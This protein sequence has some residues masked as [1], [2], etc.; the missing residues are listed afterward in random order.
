VRTL[1]TFVAV[2]AAALI[3]GC[4]VF[5]KEAH[6][7]GGYLDYVTDEFWLKADSK[8][9]RALR[10]F[11]IEASLSRIA[12]VSPKNDQDRQLMAIK[13]GATTARARPVVGCAF[14]NDN[15][16]KVAAAKTDPCFYFDSAM[17]DYSTALFDL[18]LIAFPVEDVKNLLNTVS[19]T[20]INPVSAAELLTP[21]L[22]VAKD[23]LKYGRIVG[24]LY[25]DTVELEVQVWLSTPAQDQSDIPEAY[26]ITE[27]TVANL[28]AAYNRKNDDMVAWVAEIAALR[29]QG[30]EPIP[31][32]KFILE[33]YALI[34]Y[35]CGLITQAQQ[36]DSLTTCY[37]TTPIAVSSP[38]QA[39][40]LAST[41]ERFMIPK[42]VYTWRNLPPLVTAPPPKKMAKDN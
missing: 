40:K 32:P 11:A 39:A 5:D 38:A 4:A 31:D 10:A 34:Q 16:T 7:R 26:R 23:A 37:A 15:P 33:L 1:S 6:N 17:V 21:L 27:A 2:C 14:D 8:K 28:R 18:A 42:N 35:T 29:K 22:S 9:M 25:R 30:L 3:A 41:F 13:I 36:N 19:G 12:S 24:A 20:A